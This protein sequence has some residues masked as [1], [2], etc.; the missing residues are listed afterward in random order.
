M[1]VLQLE[2]CRVEAV[3]VSGGN[4]EAD[5]VASLAANVTDNGVEDA[6]AASLATNWIVCAQVRT[7][8]TKRGGKGS[9]N[10]ATDESVFVTKR[11]QPGQNIASSNW[12]TQLHRWCAKQR[13]RIAP[14]SLV[15]SRG[16]T[17]RSLVRS[18]TENLTAGA[19]AALFG[20]LAASAKG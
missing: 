6:N 3:L 17:D 20:F 7:Y 14:V 11:K 12:W 2:Q 16:R 1:S 8:A 5:I 18:A 15:L 9:D 10:A 13:L 4:C 19:C